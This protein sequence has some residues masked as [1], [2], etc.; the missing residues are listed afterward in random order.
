MGMGYRVLNAQKYSKVRYA[1]D[2]YFGGSADKL[3]LLDGARGIDMQVFGP[4]CS[5]GGLVSR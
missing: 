1:G 3:P 5:S 4:I 2:W